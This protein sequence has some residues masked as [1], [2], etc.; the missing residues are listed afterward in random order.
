MATGDKILA[1]LGVL[2]LAGLIG[3]IFHSAQWLWLCAPGLLFLSMVAGFLWLANKQLK[4]LN[5]L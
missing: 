4:G 3:G 2:F 5:I 1:T